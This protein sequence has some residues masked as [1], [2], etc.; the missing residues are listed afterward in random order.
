M[1][2]NQGRQGKRG[3][4]R[5]AAT[6]H[7][8]TQR[9]PGAG[10]VASSVGRHA[11]SNAVTHAG[12]RNHSSDHSS[13]F[14]LGRIG[15][16]GGGFISLGLHGGGLDLHGGLVH[17]GGHGSHGNHHSYGL[18]HY[19]NHYRPLSYYGYPYAS[20]LYGYSYSSV[21]YDRPYTY[22]ETPS[23]VYVEPYPYDST[24]V[25]PGDET[26]SAT[27][28]AQ[29]EYQALQE[30][31]PTGL[32]VEGN[33]AFSDGDFE[34]ARSLFARAML[35][36]ERDGYAKLLYAYANFA[37]GEFDLAATALRRALLTTTDL[38]DRPL[39]PRS[40]YSDQIQWKAHLS[41]LAKESAARGNDINRTFLLAYLRYATGDASTAAKLFGHL[42]KTDSKDDLT[43]LLR[44]AS[45]RQQKGK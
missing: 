44:D 30:T 9:R 24:Y 20:P 32:A 23:T 42:L 43:A 10:S 41:S 6:N 7:G 29:E 25:E 22:Y 5:Q 40:L 28:P 12:G 37:L 39:D 3:G 4:S 18:G 16:H 34:K 33:K 15:N 14:T 38:I 19:Y 8:P 31:A 35:V 21:Y 2:T 13:T 17:V 26:E 1:A 45:I 11:N 36:D 27:P